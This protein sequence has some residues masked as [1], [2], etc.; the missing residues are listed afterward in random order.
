MKTT[1]N[2]NTCWAKVNHHHSYTTH[3]KSHL[4][5]NSHITLFFCLDFSIWNLFQSKVIF[6]CFISSKNFVLP[7]P[8][9]ILEQLCLFHGASLTG[10]YELSNKVRNKLWRQE[11]FYTNTAVS[12]LGGD[13]TLIMS[14]KLQQHNFSQLFLCNRTKVKESGN[15]SFLLQLCLRRLMDRIIFKFSIDFSPSLFITCYGFE[16]GEISSAA[17]FTFLK[18][19]VFFSSS[20]SSC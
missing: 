2:A 3:S 14:V 11:H 18:T 20:L 17:T 9:A 6:N 12:T 8:P 7:K 15:I 1:R 16:P 10:S 13:T 5:G 19:L 4:R